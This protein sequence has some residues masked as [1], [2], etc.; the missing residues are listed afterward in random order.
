MTMRLAVAVAVT[1]AAAAVTAPVTVAADITVTDDF[2]RAVT[3]ESPARRNVSL[4]P[5]TTENLFSAGAGARVVAVVDHQRLPARGAAPPV[6]RQ[7]RAGQR[8]GAHR[9]RAGLGGGVAHG[10]IAR[11]V[12][13]HRALGRGGVLLRAARLRRHHRQH[14]EVRAS[15][16]HAP[17][18]DPGRL[19]AE[20]AG[21]RAR[22]AG[23]APVTVFYQIWPEPLM[24]LGA[25]TSSAACWRCAARA[26]CSPTRRFSPRA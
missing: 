2:G 20:L 16:R 23:A 24:T 8:R 4:A 3:L 12:G 15:R 6:A 14:R 5:H 13:A 17:A 25:R 21:L 7:L 26:T 9:V 22:Y 18:I 10:E 19:R 11:G 1:V